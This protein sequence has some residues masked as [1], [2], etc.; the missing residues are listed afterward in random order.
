LISLGKGGISHGS[1]IRLSEKGA[2]FLT[3][4]N[5]MY[6]CCLV[7]G[8]DG[9]VDIGKDG[10]SGILTGSGVSSIWTG[11]LYC[12]IDEYSC[13]CNPQGTKGSGG[14]AM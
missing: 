3:G 12:S 10:G 9:C 14:D 8:T 13:Q 1:G 11:G 2:V 5:G 7:P 6:S 4:A